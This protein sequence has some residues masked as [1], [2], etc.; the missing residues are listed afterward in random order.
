LHRSTIAGSK[1][2]AVRGWSPS[3]GA[4]EQPHQGHSDIV[5]LTSGID[6]FCPSLPVNHAV[7]ARKGGGEKEIMSGDP[8]EM[9]I[10][11]NIPYNFPYNQPRFQVVDG[12]DV[13]IWARAKLK[14]NG[15]YLV[16]LSLQKQEIARLFYLTHRD[17]LRGVLETLC[18]F[19]DSKPKDEQ[20]N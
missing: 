11:F 5:A 1:S 16:R 18:P 13:L 17:Q 20:E 14:M 8:V 15:D 7:R 6:N 4:D 3:Q 12:K 10:L 9:P 19:L 2:R